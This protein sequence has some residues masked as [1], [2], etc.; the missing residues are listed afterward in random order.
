MRR[1]V[2]PLL[3]GS[4]TLA[5]CSDPEREV[6]GDDVDRIEQSLANGSQLAWELVQ[7]EGR[8]AAMCM[9]DS[10]FEIHQPSALHG[11]LSPN[12]FEGFASPYSRIPTVEQ[13]EKF[14]FGLWISYGETP[15]AEAMSS[16]PDYLAFVADDMGWSDP[17]EDA[18]Y[19][20]WDAQPQEYKDAWDEAFYGAERVEYSDAMQEA[21]EEDPE[22]EFDPAPEPPFGGCEAETLEIVYGGPGH[23]EIDGED[24]WFR[25]LP[26]S[27]LTWVRDGDI[28]NELSAH[29]AD[30]EQDFLFCVQD[31]GYGEWEFDDF[32][33]LPTGSYLEQLYSPGTT[34]EGGQEIPP[35][36]EEAE[37]AADPQ[38]YEFAMA[39]D[40]AQCAEDS[41][42][43]DGS[44]EA[45]GEL[46]VQQLIDRETEVFAWEQEI[47]DYL[48]NAQDHIAGP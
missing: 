35:L 9:E 40:F 10:G 26:E 34:Y 16:D 39:L 31:R 20:E 24:R 8:V 7:A 12:R 21:F 45:W 37:D 13:A 6:T 25:P 47:K 43:R 3:I 23:D 19:E 36:T 48:A 32:G 38:T 1:I 2:V 33:W 41:G 15:E 14:A 30:Q 22:A 28:Y 17:A 42:L 29:Y 18:A 11:S 5:A 46:F 27:P 4:L 44:E